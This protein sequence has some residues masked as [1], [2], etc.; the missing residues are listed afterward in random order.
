MH[1]LSEIAQFSEMPSQTIDFSGLRL[2]RHL[3]GSKFALLLLQ[4]IQQHGG[5]FLVVNP[6]DLPEL[7][8]ITSS[9]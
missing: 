7:S 9:G 1:F 5:E 3:L 8:R 2:D 6:L 4:F